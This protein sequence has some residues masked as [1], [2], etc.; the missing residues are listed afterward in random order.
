MVW[1]PSAYVRSIVRV[2]ATAAAL[3]AMSGPASAS[4]ALDLVRAARAHEHAAR[5]DLAVRRYMDALS[6]DPVCQEAYLGLGS[7]RARLGDLREA[8]RVYSVALARLPQLREARLARA[9][10]RRALGATPEATEDLFAGLDERRALEVLATWHGEDGHRPAQLAVWRKL[11]AHAKAARDARR[12][13]EART[14]VRALV[15]LVG[16]ADPAASPADA[17][18]TRALLAALARRGEV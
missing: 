15:L 13:R 8:E 10:V 17:A 14:M 1:W 12:E 5:H 11:A 3:V 6:I 18:G 7:L 4:S 16:S 9:Y 2:V